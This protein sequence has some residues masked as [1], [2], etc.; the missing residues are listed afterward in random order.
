[1]SSEHLITRQIDEYIT[2]K[3]SLGFKISVE[4][5]ELRRFAAFTRKIDHNGSLTSELAMQ[6]ATLSSDYSHSYMARRLET[7]HTF[8][9]YISAFDPQA[10]IPQLGVFGKCHGRVSPYIYTDEEVSLLM[11]EAGNLFS[12]DGIRAYTV[13]LAI[14]LLRATGMRV[15]ELT[16]LK[17]EDVHM[18]EGYLFINSSKFKKSRIVPLHPTVIEELSKY[19]EFIA[20]K[21]GNR[22]ESD[23]YFIS[24]YGHKFNTRAFEY[25]FKLIRQALYTKVITDNS[26]KIRLYDLRHTFACETVRHWLESGVDVNQKLY[27]LSTY[28]GHVKPEDTYWY[29]S[30]TPELLAISCARYEA[31][32][33]SVSTTNCEG[34]PE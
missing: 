26:R 6:W 15:S 1:M 18:D 4:A 27:L 10:Q 33:G 31:A 24:S 34:V 11:A 3:R 29:L 19:R 20:K 25:A 9:K 23:Y 17:N 12:P 8:A 5:D 21:L 13:S 22:S 32:F 30:A 16:L 2:Y 14:G 7:I 28:M